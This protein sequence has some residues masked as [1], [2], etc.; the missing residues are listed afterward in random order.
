LAS[1]NTVYAQL[2]LDVGPEAV[3][4]MAHRLGVQ[5]ALDVVPAM[6]LGAD[7]IS[8]LEEAS[9]YT[10]LAAGGVYSKPMAIRKVVLANGRW[11]PTPGASRSAGGR[12]PAS[13]TSDADPPGERS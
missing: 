4:D 3:A 6:G 7:A 9:A 13:P 8:P 1:D 10:T 11:T 12:S 2:T 5:S